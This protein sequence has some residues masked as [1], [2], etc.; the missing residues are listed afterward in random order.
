M[1]QECPSNSI[2]TS[3]RVLTT[4]ISSSAFRAGSRR[5]HCSAPARRCP[6]TRPSSKNLDDGNRHHRHA[7]RPARRAVSRNLS[8]GVQPDASP[9][10]ARSR[11][12]SWASA[13][14]FRVARGARRTG[15]RRRYRSV[16]VNGAAL[17]ARRARQNRGFRQL[18][19]VAL[20]D[21]DA[22]ERDVL[23]QG[24]R[25]HRGAAR[26]ATDIAVTWLESARTVPIKTLFAAKIE[27]DP[28]LKDFAADKWG[29]SALLAKG[30]GGFA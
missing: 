16:E 24:R 21:S 30:D 9:S 11:P 3:R 15:A 6:M 25:S 5:E 18:A 14:R 12:I 7:T 22:L 13:N 4:A 27:A 20:Q 23:L 29:H 26:R 2:M 1:Q 17:D 8:A 28:R 10:S 19:Q